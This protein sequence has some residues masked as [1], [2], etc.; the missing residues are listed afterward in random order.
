MKTEF[1]ISQHKISRNGMASLL[2]LATVS[3]FFCAV[4]FWRE[5]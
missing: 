5:K 1:K 4:L 3:G 2:A